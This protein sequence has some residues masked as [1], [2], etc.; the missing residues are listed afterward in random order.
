MQLEQVAGRARGDRLA[1]GGVVR[2]D[3]TSPDSSICT[4]INPLSS[5][6]FPGNAPGC[7]LNSRKPPDPQRGRPT[8][9]CV[10]TVG[11]ALPGHRR[12]LGH[13]HDLASPRQARR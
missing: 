1:A 7:A 9:R 11:Q 13:D 3:R 5:K 10:A 2:T 4:A 12:R 8:E 6:N